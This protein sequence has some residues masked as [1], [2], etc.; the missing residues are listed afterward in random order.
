MEHVIQLGIHIDDEAIQ[1]G[2]YESAEKT[3]LKECSQEFQRIIFNCDRWGQAG[4]S[5]WTK[6]Q[7]SA[8]MDRNRNEI[9]DKAAELLAD[10]LSRS[11]AVREVAG[12]VARANR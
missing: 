3:I 6:D 2:V 12:E 1:K 5:E 4:V 7:F 8:F 9:I 10:R 11:K